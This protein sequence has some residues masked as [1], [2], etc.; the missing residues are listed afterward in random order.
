MIAHF[1]SFELSSSLEVLFTSTILS[2]PSEALVRPLQSAT[3]G[4]V[5]A[6]HEQLAAGWGSPPEGGTRRSTTL[7]KVLENLMCFY[8]LKILYFFHVI[9]RVLKVRKH[10]A[11]VQQVGL[12][13][14]KM[15][16]LLLRH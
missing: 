13:H 10:R 5:G 12:R 4:G 14:A 16:P 6:P 15:V 11:A 9:V 1:L 8:L 3:K 2:S 7:C